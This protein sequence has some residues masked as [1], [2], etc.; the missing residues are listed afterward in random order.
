MRIWALRLSLRKQ[1][2]RRSFDT[3]M[4]VVSSL[5][6]IREGATS[7][8]SWGAVP[9]RTTLASGATTG[10]TAGLSSVSVCIHRKKGL[11]CT[12]GRPVVV[13][14]ESPCNMFHSSRTP[15]RAAP[16]F[17]LGPPVCKTPGSISAETK[18][19]PKVVSVSTSPN[20]LATVETACGGSNGALKG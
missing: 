14:T 16:R 9:I 2:R 4:S 11:V 18:S 15:T 5:T 19:S 12:S 8:S 13:H 20:L 6:S 7:H 17:R 3:K 10:S 1:S